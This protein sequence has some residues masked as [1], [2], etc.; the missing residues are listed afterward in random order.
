VELLTLSLSALSWRQHNGPILLY[1]DSSG[2]RWFQDRK[3]DFLWNAGI[4]TSALCALESR[5][6]PGVFWAAGKLAALVH[7]R[8]PVVMMDLDFIAWEA[9]GQMVVGH[10]L[11]TAHR[12]ELCP[13]VYPERVSLGAPAGYMYDP[14]WDWDALACNTA[15][16]YFN[17]DSLRDEY[18][19][20]AFRFMEGNPAA[21]AEPVTHMVF[22]EQ[23]LLGMVAERR[24]VS[25]GEFIPGGRV[26]D[27]GL[28]THLWGAKHTMDMAARKR[29]CM[30]AAA[31]IVRDHSFAAESLACLPNLT[32]YFDVAK[33]NG[34][35]ENREWK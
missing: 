27:Q 4:D 30:D 13:G 1:T 8:C 6:E 35:N 18:V 23:R 5:V 31:R 9:I 16:V 12:E 2:A 20:E 7:E 29:Y 10:N 14:E 25:I 21:P 33:R 24:G 34:M 15:F 3:L 26:H 19:R 22:A 28:F 32:A 11:V 17:D